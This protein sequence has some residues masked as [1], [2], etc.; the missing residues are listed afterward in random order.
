MGYWACQ[1]PNWAAFRDL[2]MTSPFP[3][4]FGLACAMDI[5]LKAGGRQAHAYFHT[6]VPLWLMGFHRHEDVSV[7]DACLMERLVVGWTSFGFLPLQVCCIRY[8]PLDAGAASKKGALV[9]PT[10]PAAFMSLDT[11]AAHVGAHMRASAHLA[12]ISSGPASALH[13]DMTRDLMRQYVYM[14]VSCAGYTHVLPHHGT[15]PAC[16]V[17]GDP[18]V[19]V[20]DDGCQHWVW[21]DTV[22]GGDGAIVHSDCASR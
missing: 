3:C 12:V 4:R 11:L 8:W 14:S 2:C 19:K 10:C 6:W 15:S 20:Y 1:E 21:H 22:Q 18:I 9:C 13:A 7:P 16:H 5:A 17:C